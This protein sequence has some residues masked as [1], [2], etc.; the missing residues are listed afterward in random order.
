[1]KELAAGLVPIF[2]QQGV[3]T[4][5]RKALSIFCRAVEQEIATTELARQVVTFLYRAQHHPSL[6][7]EIV[8]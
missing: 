1:V 4:E 3:H 2:Q 5:A 8:R 7:F 6:R